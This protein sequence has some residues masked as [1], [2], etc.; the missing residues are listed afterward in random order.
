MRWWPPAELVPARWG[1]SRAIPWGSLPLGLGDVQ[2]SG[3]MVASQL[4]A[5][6]RGGSGDLGLPRTPFVLTT[7]FNPSST[8]D[9]TPIQMMQKGWLWHLHKLRE[10]GIF[11]SVQLLN[12]NTKYGPERAYLGSMASNAAS[13]VYQG[14]TVSHGPPVPWYD[15]C[16]C[17]AMA[18]R[19]QWQSL[20][21]EM[22]RTLQRSSFPRSFDQKLLISELFFQTSDRYQA[23]LAPEAGGG[24]LLGTQTN[25]NLYKAN[26]A[27]LCSPR[28]QGDGGSRAPG[29]WCSFLALGLFGRGHEEDFTICVE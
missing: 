2:T 25:Y 20:A 17:S 4:W 28:G 12:V 1:P 13:L 19:V 3:L 15:A 24:H 23:P 26:L 16:R 9:P 8:S 29:A 22:P 27:P 10:A 18:S 6:R 5:D 14:W 7:M 21:P 11:S